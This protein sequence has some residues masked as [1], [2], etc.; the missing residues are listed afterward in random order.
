MYAGSWYNRVGCHRCRQST[1]CNDTSW[2]WTPLVV[3]CC[4]LEVVSI[5]TEAMLIPEALLMLQ[6]CIFLHF[7]SLSR[8][9]GSI[10]AGV[11]RQVSYKKRNRATRSARYAVCSC[12][13]LGTYTLDGMRPRNGCQ[14]RRRAP[15][16]SRW[17]VCLQLLV[18]VLHGSPSRLGAMVGLRD[19]TNRP[20]YLFCHKNE[21]T[22]AP[23]RPECRP[24]APRV[25]PPGKHLECRRPL[26][27]SLKGPGFFRKKKRRPDIFDPQRADC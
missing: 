12:R 22:Y 4:L 10:Q 9:P 24:R 13:G 20:K 19:P 6:S 25:G 8:T 3:L 14:R 23:R 15:S 1:A 17:P 5:T 21:V 7:S 2:V 26:E 16:A 18:K 27:L 11:G